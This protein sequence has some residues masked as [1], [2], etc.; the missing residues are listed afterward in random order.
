VGYALSRP[1]AWLAPEWRSDQVDLAGVVIAFALL[2]ATLPWRIHTAWGSATPW[3]SLGL[4]VEPRMAVGQILG[5]LVQAV[6]LLGL[7]AAALVLSSQARWSPNLAPDLVLNAL[8]LGLGVGLAE[9]VLFRGWLSGELD[10][11]LGRGRALVLQAALF[12]LIHPW[13]RAPGLQG[14]ALLGGLMLLGLALG[15]RKQRDG[16]SLWGPVGLHGGLVGGWFLV[17]KGLLSIAP[18]APRW[19]TGPGTAGDVNPI[20]GVVGLV[21][22]VGLVWLLRRQNG[23]T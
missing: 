7:S 8:V 23:Q 9:E 4:A 12:A 10:L 5:G 22:M 13:Y 18:A 21:G 6:V 19:W 1:L 16:G 2:L 3:R 17:Q 20:G 14:I 11:Q 15:L